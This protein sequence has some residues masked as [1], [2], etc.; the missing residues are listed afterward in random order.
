MAKV[1]RLW[2]EAVA[3]VVLMVNPLRDGLSTGFHRKSYGFL[4]GFAG[5]ALHVCDFHLQ[6]FF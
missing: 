5:I 2:I 3:F 6:D 1:G 4:E